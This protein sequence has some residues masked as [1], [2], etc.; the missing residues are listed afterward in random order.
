MT[1]PN[2]ACTCNQTPCDRRRDSSDNVCEHYPEPYQAAAIANFAE[3]L[4]CSDALLDQLDVALAEEIV[5][6]VFFLVRDPI[7]TMFPSATRSA[8]LAAFVVLY[9][10]WAETTTA[11]TRWH[12][13]PQ[14]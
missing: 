13:K 10:Q 14:A 1:T 2:Q 5:D 3:D 8:W 4:G 9:G 7:H 12:K 6:D 11:Y